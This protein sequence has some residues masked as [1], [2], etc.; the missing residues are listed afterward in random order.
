M[1][2]F[3]KIMLSII[4]AGCSGTLA[5][6]MNPL[7]LNPEERKALFDKVWYSLYLGHHE[8]KLVH[9]D[10]GN[11]KSV[12]IERP[13]VRG[14][15][16]D[17]F[18]DAMRTRLVCLVRTLL[19]AIPVEQRFQ[20]IA[21]SLHS[22]N[23]LI[24]ATETGEV[25]IVRMLL[26][27]IPQEQRFEFVM[28]RGWEGSTAIMIAVEKGDLG[29]VRMLL[30]VVPQGQRIAALMTSDMARFWPM[31]VFESALRK[32]NVAMVRLLL[33]TVP[34]EQR[35]QVI[36]TK[37]WRGSTALQYA[38]G[39]G[40]AAIVN[41]FAEYCPQVAPQQEER[42]SKKRPHDDGDGSP[43]DLKKQETG[44]GCNIM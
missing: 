39:N 24:T 27:I 37:D 40:Q 13:A 3:K 44:S 30:E 21:P 8:W 15:D 14:S 32:G 18:H 33:E 11:L 26:D 5:F 36:M 4:M 20:F 9:R 34:A 42:E 41:I 35:L 19:E 17:I 12:T 16:L 29:I 6:G 43:E 31:T 28:T 10:P 7:G 25:E 1:K 38:E 22:Y 2:I 23:I